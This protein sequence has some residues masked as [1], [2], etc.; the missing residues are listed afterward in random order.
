M[1][2]LLS[3]VAAMVGAVALEFVL[4][5]SGF[6]GSHPALT[7]GTMV[8]AVGP[9]GVNFPSHLGRRPVAGAHE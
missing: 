4:G 6:L 1:F 8:T 7:I 3:G 2:A 9:L 5:R